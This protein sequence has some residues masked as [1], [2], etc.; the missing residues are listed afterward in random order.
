MQAFSPLGSPRKDYLSAAELL[1]SWEEEIKDCFYF[2]RR[3]NGQERFW[4]ISV[5]SESEALDDEDD[6]IYNH[7]DKDLP[8]IPAGVLD[9]LEMKKNEPA[10]ELYFI[11]FSPVGPEVDDSDAASSPRSL[12]ASGISWRCQHSAGFYSLHQYC[13]NVA[14]AVW[15]VWALK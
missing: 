6:A 4:W 2:D 5:K 11:K 13:P 8:S 7:N 9:D 12:S 10:A 1:L 15:S 3:S 14:A